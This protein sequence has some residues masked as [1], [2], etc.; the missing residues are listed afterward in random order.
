MI[1]KLSTVLIDEKGEPLI[2]RDKKIVTL[3]VACVNALLA[4]DP[5]ETNLDNKVKKY[6]LHLRMFEKEEVEVTADEIV[7]LKNC[8]NVAYSQP[9][10]VGR[11]NDLLE[12]KVKEG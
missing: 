11:A 5:K 3:G 4:P 2:G 1:I 10:V 7:L 9:L 12:Q 6:H 8:I